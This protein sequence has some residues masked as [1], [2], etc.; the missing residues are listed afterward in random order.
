VAKAQAEGDRP[1]AVVTADAPNLETVNAELGDGLVDH[2]VEAAGNDALPFVAG[3]EQVA[4]FAG[5]VPV[6]VAAQAEGAGRP[7]V[8]LDDEG[9][10]RAR[11]ERLP[12]LT[13]LRGRSFPGDALPA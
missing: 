9:V 6:G 1:A 10:G 5:R 3:G 7:A 8:D 2:D 12:A 13:E 4:E 11:A